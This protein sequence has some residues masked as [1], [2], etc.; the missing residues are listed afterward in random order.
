MSQPLK[1]LFKWLPF[2]LLLSS[3][4]TSTSSLSEEASKSQL[5]SSEMSIDSSMIPSE[6]VSSDSGEASISSS[7]TPS[8]I[9]LT[10]NVTIPID[11]ET[12]S[13]IKIAGNL[14]AWNPLHED[15]KM[16]EVDAFHYTLT[17]TF[18]ITD[19]GRLLEYKYVLV[20]EGQVDNPWANVEGGA[21]GNEIG[22]RRYTLKSGE[23]I[24]NDTVLTFKHNIDQTSLT[25]GTL[26]KVSLDMP[27]YGDGRKRT[28]R[29]W[30]PDGYVATDTS[31][32]YPVLYMHDGQNLFDSYTSFSGEWGID[33][34]I[35]AL[36][37]Q[38]YGGAIVV[39]ID[40]S[41]D[42]LNEYSPSW[43]RSSEGASYIQNPS[44]EKFASFIVDTVKPYIDQNFNTNPA[45]EATGVGGSSMG[46][47]ISFYMA[48]QYPDTFGYALLFSTAMWVYQSS[49]IETFLDG[50]AISSM[51]NQPK[52]YL[53]AGGQEPSVTPYVDSIKNAL[54]AR[55]FIDSNIATHVDPSRGHNEA[56]WATYFPIAFRWLNGLN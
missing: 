36:M 33:E 27:Q 52:I 7:F 8:S 46:G 39:G 24:V 35:G 55:S 10:F 22:N 3:C 40:N 41:N 42:R 44:G 48:L 53:Y 30:L 1:L 26:T 25:R 13:S 37:D 54:I 28:I 43:P 31:K 45:R 18:P 38:G 15:Y 17:L 16:D 19:V 20:F 11:I 47:V 14:N 12:S 50:L 56:A 21:T 4:G 9:S 34:S 23:Q 5:A 2:V 32:R 6:E 49:V 29:I 51:I